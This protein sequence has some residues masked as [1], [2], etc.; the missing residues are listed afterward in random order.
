MVKTAKT[1]D[2]NIIKNKSAYMFFCAEERKVIKIEKSELNNKEI[3]VE[4]GARWKILKSENNSKLQEYEKLALDDKER[5]I[6]EKEKISENKES[7]ED[8][9]ETNEDEVKTKPKKQ[10]KTKKN[11]TKVDDSTDNVK[12]KTK[13]N[14]Y[15][16]YCKENRGKFKTEHPEILPKDVTKK[17]SIAWKELTDEEKEKYKY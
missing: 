9:E 10:V 11:E 4:L 16:N 17:L 13:I 1:K 2:N 3:L 15:I 5:Y 6:G 7:N 14:G 8:A 12:T